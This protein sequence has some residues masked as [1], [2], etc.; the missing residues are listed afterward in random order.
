MRELNDE[1]AADDEL[2]AAYARAHEALPRR[3]RRF[4]DVEEID[5][6]SAG[7]MPTRVKCLHA[8]RRP[9][10]RR[11][12]G[13]NPIGDRA[14]ALSTWSPDRCVVREPGVDEPPGTTGARV[15]ETPRAE[16]MTHR[17][18]LRRARRRRQDRRCGAAGGAS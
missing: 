1:L 18:R 4:G 12:P 10:A 14:L 6:I 11:G 8:A 2:A 7:G 3:P 16:R 15:D 17:A 9:R 13:V 5:G